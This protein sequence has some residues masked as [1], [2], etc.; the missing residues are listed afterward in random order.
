MEAKNN[1]EKTDLPN[2]K[3]YRFIILTFWVNY[4]LI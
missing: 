2:G 1:N 3:I 4:V